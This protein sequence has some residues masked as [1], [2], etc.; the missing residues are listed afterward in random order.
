MMMATMQPV[1]MLDGESFCWPGR[2]LRVLSHLPHLEHTKACG[3][4]A[5]PHAVQR[6][7]VAVCGAGGGVGDAWR[8]DS[9]RS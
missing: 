7:C 2:L 8:L 6:C 9:D 1:G 3:G 5:A 4:T